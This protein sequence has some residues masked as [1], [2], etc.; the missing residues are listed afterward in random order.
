MGG[1]KKN[2]FL[3]GGY[4]E[5]MTPQFFRRSISP[6]DAG[7]SGH[8]GSEWPFFCP[9]NTLKSVFSDFAFTFSQYMVMSWSINYYAVK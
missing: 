8:S 9:G 1:V 6:A 3:E 2:F 7:A 5:C 4:A